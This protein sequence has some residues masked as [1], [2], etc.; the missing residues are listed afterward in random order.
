MNWIADEHYA[1]QMNSVVE[2][3]LAARRETGFD[4]RVPG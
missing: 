3:Y 2:P 1:E 4:E